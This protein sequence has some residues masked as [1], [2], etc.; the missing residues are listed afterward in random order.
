MNKGT[1]YNLLAIVV[2]ATTILPGVGRAQDTFAGAAIG[3]GLT[4][5]GNA[6]EKA[7]QQ[8][9]GGG[10]MLEVQAG[11]QVTTAIQQ[12]RTAFDHEATLQW[13]QLNAAERNT[14]SSVASIA[15]E[16][17]DKTYKNATEL[18]ARA[19]AVVHVLPFAHNFPQVFA[20]GPAWAEQKTPSGVH[21]S[22]RGDFVDVLR[23]NYDATVTVGGK[24]I[25]N[26]LKT[27]QQIGFDIPTTILDVRPSE[28][29]ENVLR[30]RIPYQTG[31]IVHSQK[32]AELVVPLMILP[33]SLGDI[34]FTTNTRDPSIERHSVTSPEMGQE[35]SDDDIKCGGEHADLAIHTWAP[36]PGWRVMPETVN[37]NVTWSQGRQG[38]GQDWWL[39]RNCS[40]GSTA[41]LCISTEHHGPGTSGKVHFRISFTE[42]R[43]VVLDHAS[44]NKVSLHWGESR[45]VE[46]PQGATW[47][48]AYVRWDGKRQEF[49]GGYSDEFVH[50]SQM[51]N[52]VTVK[53]APFIGQ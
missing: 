31:F 27:S 28:P 7:V 21:L 49:I 23:P 19:Q 41:C 6:V 26:H 5:L 38:N 50:V 51:G 44:Q 53:A 43:D 45:V 17:V 1:I 11:G 20:Y 10:L 32:W 46:V 24:E 37:W 13:S 4:K 18:E 14:L 12:A 9:V 35:S 25:K 30:L 2:V 34:V 16:F 40:N 36:E 39:E 47:R 52:A 8:A 48:G 29:V 22:V 15:N 42:E 3:V 33:D